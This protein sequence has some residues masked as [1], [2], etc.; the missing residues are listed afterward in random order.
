MGIQGLQASVA[1]DS[2]K[3]VG[4]HTTTGEIWA[5]Y[6]EIIGPTRARYLKSGS[7]TDSISSFFDGIQPQNCVNDVYENSTG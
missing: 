7:N 4:I 6:L 3:L 5:P 2:I 1:S